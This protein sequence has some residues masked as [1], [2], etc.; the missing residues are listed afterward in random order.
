L[1]T[2]ENVYSIAQNGGSAPQPGSTT[3]TYNVNGELVAFTDNMATSK[4]N[5][6]I[7]ANNAQGQAIN[8]LQGASGIAAGF[9][10]ALAAI[11]TSNDYRLRSMLVA[12]GQ[13]VGEV[14]GSRANF[15]VNYTPV[16][17]HYPDST[18]SEV[19]A[20]SGDTLRAVAQRVFG[21]ATLWYLI[22]QENGLSEPDAKLTAGTLLKIPNQVISLPNT[23]NSFK[24]YN[25]SQAIGD[26]TPTQP[27]PPV[28]A[29]SGGHSGGC[30]VLGMVLVIIVVIV[31][32]IY[33]A[34]LA[35]GAAG[36]AA[37]GTGAS[38]MT[39]TATSATVGGLGVVGSA[40]VGA[41]VGSAAG[42]LVGMAV[43]VQ[44]KFSWGQVAL[45][46]L[47]AGVAQG[48]SGVSVFG[49]TPEAAGAWYNVAARGAI[50]N[51][52]M[53]GASMVLGV[54]KSF[55]W[56]E[57]AIS[58]ASAVV[59][60]KVGRWAIDNGAKRDGLG[61]SL[62]QG[63]SSG[64]VRSA[65]GGNT[66]YAGIIYDAFGRAIGN[67]I[68]ARVAPT[69]ASGGGAMSVMD[70]LSE[71]KVAAQRLTSNPG[72]PSVMSATADDVRVAQARANN[73][74]SGSMLAGLDEISITA[75]RIQ[76]M[77]PELDEVVV[78][79][80]RIPLLSRQNLIDT[81]V[82]IGSNPRRA[83]SPDVRFF[84]ADALKYV[85]GSYS[86]RLTDKE[87]ERR[88]VLRQTLNAAD[89]VNAG[90]A[91]LMALFPQGMG[92]QQRLE[93][94]IRAS[95][96]YFSEEIGDNLLAQINS[97]ANAIDLTFARGQS[98]QF[99]GLLADSQHLWDDAM[100]ES[101]TGPM[102]TS[103]TDGYQSRLRALIG[104]DS[105]LPNFD[106]PITEPGVMREKWRAVN[107]A[108]LFGGAAD[109]LAA[110][111][112][113]LARGGVGVAGSAGG[114]AIIVTERG[115]AITPEVL[116]L[117]G[118]SKLVGDFRG[119]QG[120]TV[121][122]IVSRVPSSWTVASQERG[123]GIRFFDEMGAERLRLHG[124]SASAPAGSNSAAG[125]TARIQVPGTTNRYYDNLGNI[126]G[127]RANEGHIPIYG[128]PKIGF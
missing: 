125:W 60:D 1:Q 12:N 84:D 47:S 105:L 97:G 42:Q 15:D 61:M 123:Q 51:A 59:S 83:P 31:V 101:I 35:A 5:D 79:A 30:G 69:P 33:T 106:L 107:M 74:G 86:G 120:A 118:T 38:V 108:G 17:S 46:A 4:V 117:Q 82:Q 64:V 62:A 41:A 114:R 127:A 19:V 98:E 36:S 18:P 24:P 8:V 71:V 9:G 23:A 26:T 110:G 68:A 111:P 16:S 116:N 63:L 88:E 119:I 103:V 50:A 85:R 52:T 25:V 45:S 96:G 87:F 44:D 102:P 70:E 90:D 21:D 104:T 40:M 91:Q 58:A 49:S 77:V 76:P 124:P 3:R 32:S 89:A 65:M 73:A 11:G 10:T 75:T 57:V 7:F 126:V 29:A 113:M 94:A 121:E 109:L 14:Q 66:D 80:Q 78:S 34:G 115:V 99:R 93:E 54:Q 43:G 48:L 56:S 81:L 27:S 13:Q 122:E 53:Q 67:S 6:R 20:Q 95:G 39:G 22:A 128:N 55:N 112:L 72:A 2:T 92:P 100:R 28:V 37:W